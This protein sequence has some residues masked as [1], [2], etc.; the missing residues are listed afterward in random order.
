[1]GRRALLGGGRAVGQKERRGL[2]AVTLGPAGG[3]GLKALIGPHA[4][5]TNC[6]LAEITDGKGTKGR[7]NLRRKRVPRCCNS[8]ILLWPLSRR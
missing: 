8:N 6:I 3:R 2:S 1:M 7:S 5:V 4:L